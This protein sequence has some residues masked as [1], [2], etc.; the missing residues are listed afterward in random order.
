MMRDDW[1]RVRVIA[2][3]QFGR[4]AGIALFPEK[5]EIHYSRTGR[6]RQIL[7]QGRRIAT[8]KTDG[9]LTLSIEGAMMLHR[10]LPY[11]RMRVVVGDEAA[12]FVRDG[13]NAF[14]RHVVEVD[15]EIRALDEVLIVDR[16]DNLLGTGKA[17]LSAAEM[18]SFRRGVAVSVRAGV[19][20]R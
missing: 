9:L 5:P 8:L 13:K 11:P 2:N 17:L 7:Y 6:I 20:A 10:Y 12:R 18:L 19:G 16:S 15:P 14:A 4:G 1:K 3:Y